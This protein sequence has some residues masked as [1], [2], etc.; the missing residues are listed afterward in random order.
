MESEGTHILIA[1]GGVAAL[2][3]AFALQSL[4]ED[5]LRVELV[6]PKTRF[7]YRP[8]AVA[9]PFGR[10]EVG[11]SSFPT[12]RRKPARRSRAARSSRWTPRAVSCTAGP[13]ALVR[14]AAARV[15][16]PPAG[17]RHRRADVPRACG[18]EKD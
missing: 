15:R 4:A 3:A 10:G 1:G 18:H 8:L 13:V 16:N 11:T 9:E 7:W 17:G 2:E 12:W 5:R 14:F 6:A